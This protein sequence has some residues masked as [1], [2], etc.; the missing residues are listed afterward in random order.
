RFSTVRYGNVVGSRG[1]VVP[2]FK[3]QAETGKI[4]LTDDR[5]TRFWITLEQGVRFV[6]SCVETM[7]GGEV[8]IPKLP[9]MKISDLA[10]LIAPSATIETVGIR[11]GEKLHEAMISEDEAR[12]AVEFPDRFIIKPAHAW[13]N[14]KHWDTGIALPDGFEY[15]SDTND[16]WLDEN[17]MQAMIT[18]YSD[19]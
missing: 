2:L 1:S 15:T 9:S 6:L 14:S 5:M 13:W 10:K 16:W 12:Q 4:T 17:E 18:S 11:P 7:H 8:F 3:Q 19:D